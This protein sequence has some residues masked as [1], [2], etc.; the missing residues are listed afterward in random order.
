MAH[1]FPAAGDGVE[2]DRE[3]RNE[4]DGRATL[5]GGGEVKLGVSTLVQQ[6][7]DQSIHLKKRAPA[8][9]P[10]MPCALDLSKEVL[11]DARHNVP[12][13]MVRAAI[14]HDCKGSPQRELVNRRRSARI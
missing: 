4:E 10:D 12:V 7:P 14:N 2:D 5:L 3:A 6:L 9:T 8:L 13:G 11:E 1:S